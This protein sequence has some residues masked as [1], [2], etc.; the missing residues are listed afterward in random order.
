[1]KLARLAR[2][3]LREYRAAPRFV[4]GLLRDFKADRRRQSHGAERTAPCCFD[5]TDPIDFLQMISFRA[6]PLRLIAAFAAAMLFVATDSRASDCNTAYEQ[7]A[8]ASF[9]GTG[10]F[11]VGREIAPVMGHQ[12]AS[13]LERPEREAE[14]RPSVLIKNLPLHPNAMVADLGAGTGYFALRIAPLVP[15]GKVYAIDIQ[16]E[17]LEIIRQKLKQTRFQNVEPVLSRETQINVAPQSLDL[18]I[19]VDVYHELS[20]P[21]EM[22]REI[23][24]ALKPGGRLALIE[25]RAE[26]ANVPIKPLH[27]MTQAQAKKELGAAGLIW[28][29]TIDVLPWQHLMIFIKQ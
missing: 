2:N 28:E 22:G 12:G 1:M 26:D 8:T 14:E 9:D 25:Y 21:C 4:M 6:T 16:P 27:K 23:F 24:T 18:L 10:K 15:K 3:V 13:W 19:M 29:K 17:M 11:Y 7:R 5:A 20:H